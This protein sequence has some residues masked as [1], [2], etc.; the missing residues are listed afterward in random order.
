MKPRYASAFQG[1]RAS[2]KQITTH[3]PVAATDISLLLCKEPTIYTTTTI[4]PWKNDYVRRSLLCY[5]IRNTTASR[6]PPSLA[7]DPH[8][9]PR[10][11][12][13]S[14]RLSQHDRPR[15]RRV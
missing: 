6:R 13:L 5:A 12:A 2:E 7:H 9:S 4:S 10:Y 8:T 14:L 15:D 3:S 11:Q 1:T